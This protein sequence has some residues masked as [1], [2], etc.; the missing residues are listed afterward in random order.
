[1]GTESTHWRTGQARDDMVGQMCGGLHHAAG[2]AGWTDASALAGS[3]NEEV[4]PAVGAA[5]TGKAVGEDAA[6]ED[7]AVEVAAQFRLGGCGRARPG[8]I[9]L[10]RKPGGKLFKG[11][12]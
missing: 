3:G 11:P 4:V 7:A 10:A 1:L 12:L 6:V 9:L 8:A 2:G 5:G